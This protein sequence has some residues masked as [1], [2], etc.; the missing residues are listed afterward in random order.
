[1]IDFVSIPQER[2]K[3]LRTD[4]LLRTLE[5]FS[6]AKIKCNEDIEIDCDDVLLLM[7]LKEVIHA[8]GRGFDLND[9]MNLL[10][11]SF[12]LE[13]INLNDFAGKSKK[14]QLTLKGRVIGREGTM[15]EFIEKHAEV[16]VS[17]YGKTISIVGTWEK[18]QVA[19][20]AI[21]RLLNGAKH[22]TVYRFLEE[23]ELR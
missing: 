10:D 1:M 11:E 7:R 15:R 20:E 18:V 14:R 22:T 23:R 5:K 8:F 21:E 3:I 9:A 16:K 6:N 2:I 12:M 13:T 19:K 4:K 17:I